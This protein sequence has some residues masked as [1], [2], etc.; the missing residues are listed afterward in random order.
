LAAWPTRDG[1]AVPHS[2]AGRS[3]ETVSRNGAACALARQLVAAGCPDRPWQV[4]DQLGM[5]CLSGRSLHGLARL[6]VEGNR[7]RLW[8]RAR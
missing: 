8:A 3:Y 4:V 1:P 6:T 5:V 7:F 2:Y